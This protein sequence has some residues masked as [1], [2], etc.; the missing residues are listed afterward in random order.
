MILN[1]KRT[2]LACLLWCIC[3]LLVMLTNDYSNKADICKNAYAE[4][5]DRVKMQTATQAI[6]NFPPEFIDFFMRKQAN[7]ALK[8]KDFMR[9]FERIRRQLSIQKINIKTK[10]DAALKDAPTIMKR[11][12][13]ITMDLDSEDRFYHL[14]D[15]LY[16]HIPGIIMIQ[17]FEIKK[18]KNNRYEGKIECSWLRQK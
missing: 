5:M 9:I 3:A 6:L 8:N 7:K 17:N 15:R 2:F 10:N 16:H 11:D 14:I 12:L 18:N 13:I 4:L 1:Q